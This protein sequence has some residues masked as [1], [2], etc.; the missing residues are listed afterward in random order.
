MFL[1]AEGQL[2]VPAEP[3]D[4]S[5]SRDQAQADA[6]GREIAL[7]QGHAQPGVRQRQILDVEQPGERR[8][9]EWSLRLPHPRALE[10]QSLGFHVP[11][12]GAAIKD[13][14]RDQLELQVVQAQKVA[15]VRRA[16]D[17]ETRKFQG[18]GGK[19]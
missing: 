12:P 17:H 14:T 18:R 19:R 10:N 6:I 7:G 4:A 3:T 1:P 16:R 9:V 13:A 15:L 2:P 8:K 11:E 5:F